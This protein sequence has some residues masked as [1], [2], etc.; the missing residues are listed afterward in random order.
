M[1]HNAEPQTAISLETD[2][3]ETAEAYQP[4]DH[5]SADIADITNIANIELAAAVDEDADDADDDDTDEEGPEADE[6]EA[7]DSDEV[8]AE[9]EDTEDDSEDASEA[10][11]ND[12]DDSDIEGADVDDQGVAIEGLVQTKAE[13]QGAEDP[14]DDDSDD[15]DDTEDDA[16]HGVT[17]QV[18]PAGTG[19]A[20]IQ[21]ETDDE[22][23]TE[24]E[25][26][27]EDDEAT[28]VDSDDSG[29][30]DGDDDDDDDD[31]DPH[32]EFD[33]NGQ[34]VVHSAIDP[35]DDEDDPDHDSDNNE[36]ADD[37]ANMA[38]TV[39][40]LLASLQQ[41][42][43][44]HGLQCA[45]ELEQQFPN[46]R[47]LQIAGL[48]HDVAHRMSSEAMHG[49]VGADLVRPLYGDRVASLVELHV[50]AKRYL[51][52]VD[53]NYHAILSPESVHTLMLQGSTMDA[54]EQ[55]AF[56]N[57]HHF[58]DAVT[59]R[60][61][62]DEAKVPGRSVPDLAYWEPI[63]RSAAANEEIRVAA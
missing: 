61:A 6:T 33:E 39:D 13:A 10:D 53:P 12:T 45:Y 35:R 44:Q 52:T 20:Q 59:L 51:V 46:D 14:A 9:T 17:A 15:T 43:H 29:S 60:R 24:D 4:T 58:G 23:E 5:P 25:N 26:D 18:D 1:N 11:D 8:K 28:G 49:I 42:V 30:S 32:G 54:A 50:D 38:W 2:P 48:V 62:D 57:N 37:P 41:D 31:E 27:A 3:L 56:E 34:R 7:D 16:D 19:V 36:D 63:L 22:A 47:E 40:D 55:L 21:A